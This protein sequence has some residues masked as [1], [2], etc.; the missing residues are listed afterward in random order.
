VLGRREQFANTPHAPKLA[1]TLIN[2]AMIQSARAEFTIAHELAERGWHLAQESM[3][4]SDP[5]M[6]TILHDYA[7]VLDTVGQRSLAQQYFEQALE[8]RLKAGD[9]A[10]AVD[11]LASL[12]ASFYDV[13]RFV[14][15]EDRYE[16]AGALAQ[17]QLPPLHPVRAEIERSWCRVLTSVGKITESLAKCDEALAILTARAD[18]DHTEIFRT[19]V[20]R[21]MALALLGRS[22]EATNALRLAV[23]GLRETLP[24]HAPEVLQAV[25]ALGVTLVNSQHLD[26]GAA[27]LAASFRE[28]RAALGD[29]HPDVVLAEGEYGV[30]LAIQGHLPEAE[31]VLKDYAAK[32]EIMRR[33]YGRDD[34]TTVGVFSRFA[35]TRMF[36]AKLLVVQGRCEEAFDWMETSKARSLIDRVRERASLGGAGAGIRERV[37]ALEQMRAQL[38]IQRAQ[39]AGDAAQ[40]T[41]IDGKLRSIANEIDLVAKGLLLSD[42]AGDAPGTP[43][44]Q[45]IRHGGLMNTALVSFGLVDDEVLVVTYRRPA[46]FQC[47][48]LGNWDHLQDTMQATRALES[49]PGGVPGLLAGSSRIAAQ[50]LLRTGSRSYAIVPRSAAIPTGAS[51]VTSSDALLGSVGQGLMGWVVK[52]VRPVQHLVISADGVLSL[53]ALDA[54]QVDGHALVEGYSIAQVVSFAGTPALSGTVQQKSAAPN[55]MILFGDPMYGRATPEQGEK[56]SIARAA[57]IVRGSPDEGPAIWQRL[58]ASAKEVSALRSRYGLVPGRTLF[59]RGT[60]TLENVRLLAN[61]HAFERA[62]YLVFSTH[63]VADLSA[64]ELSS[65]VLSLPPGRPSRDAYLTAAEL[66][67]LSLRTELVFFSACETGYGQVAAGEG[68]LG[69][70]VGALVAG[71]RK[72]VHTLWSVIDTA[73]ADFTARFFAALQHGSN[74]QDALT[75]TK[76]HFEKD[77]IHRDAAY[78]APYVIVELWQ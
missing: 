73:T 17:Q 40:Q 44:H 6:G 72:T 20:N 48:T 45:L 77:P 35:S 70:S 53:V 69:L 43:S 1:I 62:R 15:S 52:S 71:S 50:R 51:P 13:G 28:S 46:G 7:L 23:H 61:A 12:A 10:S 8:A 63:A 47:T 31:S 2:L 55:A 34:R 24:P 3:P 41:H 60:A 42:G 32:T 30:V 36:L 66:A 16:Q 65:I 78:W 26:E 25:R 49:T 4:A 29:A 74:P 57:L 21:G 5:R 18:E 14:E 9:T 56:D 64:P 54:L 67:T 27:L 58:P 68:V 37:S 59:T 19:Q 76:R 11:S 39:I 75:A 38:Y 33:L 22:D